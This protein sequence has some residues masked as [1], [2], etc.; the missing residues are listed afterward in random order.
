MASRLLVRRLAMRAS[1]ILRESGANSG[2]SHVLNE[3]GRKE[4]RSTLQKGAKRDPE[5]YVS[6]IPT[7][8]AS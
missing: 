6:H 5:L 2:A 7:S 1:P 3:Q 8:S 4:A